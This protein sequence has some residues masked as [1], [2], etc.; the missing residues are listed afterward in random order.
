MIWLLYSLAIGGN[1]ICKHMDVLFQM[2]W[3]GSNCISF[4]LECWTFYHLSSNFGLVKRKFSTI[5]CFKIETEHYKKNMLQERKSRNNAINCSESK[6]GWKYGFNRG[7][8][9]EWARPGTSKKPKNEGFVVM[10]N[11]QFLRV[12]LLSNEITSVK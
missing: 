6:I 5:F 8:M 3:L 4:I 1:Y 7:C 9:R 12:I 10:Y 11:F 2:Q